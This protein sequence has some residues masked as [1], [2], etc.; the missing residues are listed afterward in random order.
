MRINESLQFQNMGLPE[1][2]LRMKHHGD[3]ANAIRL[4]DIRLEDENLPQCLRYCLQV[5]R[6]MMVRMEVEFPYSY[7]DALSIIRAHIP[8]F[9]KEEMDW[10]IA[11]RKIRW[12]YVNGQFRIFNRFFSSLVKAYVGFAKRANQ[13]LPGVE[14]AVGG[15]PLLDY[16][17]Q[18]MKQKGSMTNR[19][20]IRSSMKVKDEV[21]QKGMF[22]RAHL[23]IPSACE[24]QSDIRIEKIFPE[25]GTLAPEDAP[26]RTVCWEGNLEENQ[27]FCVEYSY[28]HT[29]A[30]HD[31]DC[32]AGIPGTYDFDLDEQA[33]HI[34]FTPYIRALVQEL[35]AGVEDPLQKA[36]I[37]YDFI[38]KNMSYT[39]MPSY[40]LLENIPD[41]CA[42]NFTGDCGIFALLFLTLCRCAGI[43]AQW[44]SGFTAEPNFC[45]GHDW[46]RFCV[47]PFGWLFADCSYGVAA[48]RNGNEERRRFY[49]GNL[50][51]YRM[52]ANSAFAAPFTVDKDHWRADPYDNQVGEIETADRGLTYEE[53]V[54]NKIVLSCEEV[55]VSL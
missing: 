54:R 3:Y 20:R 26:Q 35:T 44:Q 43:P 51:P 27:E 6:E 14:S 31:L 2:I 41:T 33:P 38:T 52:V 24:Q 39:F 4:I 55:V 48:Q 18:T 34:V 47:E 23:P 9:S 29:A 37:F 49:F 30:Y 40:F 21:F 28:T 1:D 19:I 5:Q 32:A 36:R 17:M 13:T 46:V 53:Y 50:D 7:D 25:N 15:I 10:L 22:L 45:G 16:S 8:D 42:Q 11:Q 12:S